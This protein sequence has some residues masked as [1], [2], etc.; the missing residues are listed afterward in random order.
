MRKITSSTNFPISE[1]AAIVTFSSTV[2]GFS[3]NVVN[4]QELDDASSIA[5]E[6]IG[7]LN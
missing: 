6:V 4:G 5:S 7:F 2:D 3:E 1:S